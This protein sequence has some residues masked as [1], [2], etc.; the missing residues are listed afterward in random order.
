M[1]LPTGGGKTPLSSAIVRKLWDEPTNRILYIAHR[2]KLIIQG[3][4]HLKKALPPDA[5]VGMVKS[6]VRVWEHPDCRLHVGSIQSLRSRVSKLGNITHIVIDEAHH[7]QAATYKK[8]SEY[9]PAAKILGVTAT[10]VKGLSSVFSDLVLGPT[11]KTLITNGYL[12]DYE[13]YAADTVMVTEGA[14]TIAG[15]YSLSDLDDRN[16]SVELSGNL[17]DSYRKYGG[18]GTCIV[19]AIN[20]EHSK[21][22]ARRYAEN[23][24]AAV[25]MDADTSESDRMEAFDKLARG[26][27]KVITNVN[28]LSEGIDI[29]SLDVMQ[30]AQPTKSLARYLQKCGRVLRGDRGI[31][32]DH[33]DNWLMHKPPC[34]ERHW[35]LDGLIL[36]PKETK[37][38][39]KKA[40]GEVIIRA[41]GAEKV[42][43]EITET[44][45]GMINIMMGANALALWWDMKINQLIKVAK[46]KE[47]KKGWI[48]HRMAEEQPPLSAWQQLADKLEYNRGWAT[49]KYNEQMA[50]IN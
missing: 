49:R 34:F 7:A 27:I 31:I 48:A 15:E 43:K 24:I 22:I 46:E 23:G 19:F 45:V 17:I 47:Y 20:I 30:D 9:W 2:D 44:R 18:G 32:I 3:K 36:P 42:E 38:V 37:E 33:T 21:Q 28:L 13:Y 10:P 25:H 40:D 39:I 8:M 16:N 5:K 6:G 12:A 1:Q 50:L 35:G 26:E 14:K 29:P 11:T 4:T 41:I